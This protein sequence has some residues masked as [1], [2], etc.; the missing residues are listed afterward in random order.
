MIEFIVTLGIGIVTAIVV[1]AALPVV[2]YFIAK[3]TTYGAYRGRM[4]ARKDANLR[5]RK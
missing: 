1:V 4:L 3:F 2:A 5:K